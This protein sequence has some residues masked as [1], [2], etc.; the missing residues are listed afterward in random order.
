MKNVLVALLALFA[1]SSCNHSNSENHETHEHHAT[2][3]HEHAEE[4]NEEITLNNGEKW[5][6]NEEMKPHIIEASDILNAFVASNSTDYTTLAEQLKEKNSALVNSCTM[7][8]ASH[9]ELHKWLH[10]HI[11][12]I[13]QLANAENEDEAKETVAS[14]QASFELFNQYFE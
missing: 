2:D 13:K 6:V 10:P 4:A 5:K 9:E 11:N 12:L 1:V 8:G 7:T 14:L 3:E